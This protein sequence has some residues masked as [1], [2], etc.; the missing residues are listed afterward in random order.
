MLS[1]DMSS[2]M[3]KT[4]SY[5]GLPE[6]QTRSR[7][8]PKGVPIS[9][10]D[11]LRSWIK[12]TGQ[13]SRSQIVATFVID[14]NGS[15]LIAD[16]HSEHVACAGG[17]QVL[18]AGEMTFLIDDDGLEVT[19]VSNQSTGYCPEPESWSQVALALD[20][21]PLRHPGK[22]TQEIV[23]RR[24]TS[25]DQINIVKDGWLVC[26]ACGKELPTQWNVG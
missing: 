23:F 3:P 24:C 6:I 18:S 26:L 10:A 21:I 5:V 14:L 12:A 17:E 4:Y 20:G 9:R 7:S 16:R 11:D 8:A 22:F 2:T 25:C 1:A 13:Q 19:D 15:L